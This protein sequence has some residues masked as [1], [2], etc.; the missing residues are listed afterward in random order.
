MLLSDCMSCI[1]FLFIAYIYIV[2]QG[3]RRAQ[4]SLDGAHY[5]VY[6]YIKFISIVCCDGQIFKEHDSY[7]SIHHVSANID[8]F[9]CIEPGG[10]VSVDGAQQLFYVP[11]VWTENHM[12]EAINVYLHNCF[13]TAYERANWKKCHWVAWINEKGNSNRKE[14]SKTLMILLAEQVSL[15]SLNWE[16]PSRVWLFQIQFD[17][18]I[19]TGL[20]A[21]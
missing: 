2:Q 15:L 8:T 16:Q 19:L 14:K 12:L 18:S 3:A 6:N 21:S 13:Y 7:V 5:I 1:A 17:F 11:L 9:C 10:Q 20:K 4:V